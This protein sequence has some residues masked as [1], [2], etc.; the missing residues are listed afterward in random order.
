MIERTPAER[1]ATEDALGRALQKLGN[2]MRDGKAGIANHEREYRAGVNQ[3]HC[4]VDTYIVLV[5][6]TL[7]II[8]IEWERVL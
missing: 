7:A 4:T 3:P 8:K 5:P 2:W 6:N 1:R